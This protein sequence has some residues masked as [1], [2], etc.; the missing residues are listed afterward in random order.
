MAFFIDLFYMGRSD[1]YYS[2]QIRNAVLTGDSISQSSE[3]IRLE[4][5]QKCKYT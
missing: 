1:G 2:L 3:L 5:S 4:L